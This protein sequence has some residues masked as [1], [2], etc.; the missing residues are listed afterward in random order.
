MKI[1]NKATG[2]FE[3]RKKYIWGIKNPALKVAYYLYD[4]DSRSMEVGAKFFKN[5]FG[6]TTTNGYN[7][8]KLFD[9]HRTGGTRYGCMV[10]VRR[11]FVEAFQTNSCSA[12]VVQLISELYWVESDCRIHFLSDAERVLERQQRSILILSA[13]WQLLKPIFDNTQDFAANLFIKAVRYAVNEWE[14]VCRYVND[15]W[16]EIDN[17]TA[18]RLMKPV[19]LGRKNY[20]F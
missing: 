8:Y 10:H 20:L 19:C 13:L 18:E 11:K 7:V 9:R 2:K 12:K 6:I 5:F 1:L 17:N 16:A 3:Y 15:D 14:A 4:Q